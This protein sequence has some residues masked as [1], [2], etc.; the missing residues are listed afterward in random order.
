TRS[1]PPAR[2]AH[3]LSTHGNRRRLLPAI[4]LPP[5]P[6]LRRGPGG[7]GLSRVHHRLPRERA[8]DG[9]VA[10]MTDFTR[11]T[12]TEWLDLADRFYRHLDE[13]LRAGEPGSRSFER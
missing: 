12:R 1:R 10:R 13:P 7:A 3:R 11:L 4:R 9:T 6:P 2:C 8:G 5:H